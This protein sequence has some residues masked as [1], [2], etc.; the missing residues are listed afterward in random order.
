MIIMHVV[1]FQHFISPNPFSLLVNVGM[2]NIDA[3]TVLGPRKPYRAFFDRQG[4]E[5][6]REKGVTWM[7]LL[8]ELFF[9]LSGM[10]YKMYKMW[11][12]GPEDGL[13][14]KLFTKLN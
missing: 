4:V 5:A 14:P 6:L 10:L 9:C 8:Q 7:K 1:V 12:L 13:A 2:K 3:M 11:F